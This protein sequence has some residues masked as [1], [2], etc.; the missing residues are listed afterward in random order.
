MLFQEKRERETIF[1]E[2]AESNSSSSAFDK[3][4]F[5]L[6]EIKRFVGKPNSMSFTKKTCIQN[7]FL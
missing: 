7:L 1:S 5:E 2:N 3:T 6:R 4:T